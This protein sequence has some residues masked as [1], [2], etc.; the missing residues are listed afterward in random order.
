MK[1]KVMITTLI[2]GSMLFFV[3][4]NNDDNNNNNNNNSNTNN[5]S[6]TENSDV[7]DT[8]DT[9]SEV[10]E[11]VATVNGVDILQ[12]DY[13][14]AYNQM[15]LSYEQQGVDFTSEEGIALIAQIEE[16]AMDRLIQKE[17]LIQATKDAGVSVTT[18]EAQLEI[19]NIK[20]QYPSEE[21][22]QKVLEDNQLTEEL[23]LELFVEE[24]SIE[25]YINSN[26]E[27]DAVTDAEALEQYEIYLAQIEGTE[28]E[29]NA[30]A[31]EEVKDAL[32][33]QMSEGREQEKIYQ[34]IDQLIE[35]SEVETYL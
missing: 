25:A 9:N 17:V 26:I 29:A 30:P 3:G 31:F 20:S 4:C 5:Q 15:K 13:L 32:K 24:M 22:F 12:E 28:D 33:E 34:F 19:E 1:F 27:I 2:V 18:E 6:N 14:E 7:I 16:G 10:P 21:D 11:I 35:D 23:L 8:D